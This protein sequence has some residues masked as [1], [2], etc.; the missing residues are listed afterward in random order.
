MAMAW[1]RTFA[2]TG[3]YGSLVDVA[4]TLRERLDKADYSPD[5]SVA[6][7][8]I[9]LAMTGVRDYAGARDLLLKTIDEADAQEDA[10]GAAWAKTTLA[11][12]Y[13]ETG[14][15]PQKMVRTLCREVITVAETSEDNH[16]HLTALYLIVAS[17]RACGRLIKALETTAAME[18]IAEKYQDRRARGY[19]NSARGALFTVVG[20]PEKA[21][22]YLEAAQNDF[23]PHTTDSRVII[24]VRTFTEIFTKPPEEI[25]PKIHR[26]NDVAAKLRDYNLIHAYAWI[27]LVLE[28]RSGG[29]TNAWRRANQ[30]VAD[31][32]A[33]QNLN[34]MNQSHMTRAEFCLALIGLIDPDAEAPPD[35]PKYPR[36]KSTLTDLLTFLRLKFTAK[37]TAERDLQACLEID[38][39][40]CGITFARAMI[41]LGLIAAARKQNAKAKQHLEIGLKFAKE[42]D[43]EILIRRA[44]R[45]LERL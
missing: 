36:K 28:L 38:Q 33:N 5:R 10:Y 7:A 25:W 9:A 15:A 12:I 4:P 31:T 8:L 6:F 11:R 26:M 27:H 16:L 3:D 42:E 22:T 14:W 1:T 18:D 23:L 24:G 20:E 17:H 44:E 19:A 37:R 2:T 21:A 34:L 32:R 45:A 30:L 35:R 43:A 29:L 13:D 40:R 39:E 41:G